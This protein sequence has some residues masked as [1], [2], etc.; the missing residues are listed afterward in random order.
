MIN[1]IVKISAFKLML[2]VIFSVV[3]TIIL[4]SCKQ[5]TE[6]LNKPT[7]PLETKYL[8]Y[9]NWYDTSIPAQI[10]DVSTLSSEELMN[11]KAKMYW[12]NI[13][14]PDVSLKDILSNSNENIQIPVLNLVYNSAER[15]CYNTDTLFSTS[16]SNWGG[17]ILVID[18]DDRTFINDNF[19]IG[20]LSLWLNFEDKLPGG[21]LTID[22]GRISEDVIPNHILDTEDKN[23]NGLLDAGE[24]KGLDGLTDRQEPGYS[25]SNQ[26]PENDDYSYIAGIDFEKINNPEGNQKLNME[27]INYNGNLDLVNSYYSYKIPINYDNNPY[28][29]SAVTTAGWAHM[30]IKLT[31]FASTTGVPSKTNIETLRIWISGINKMVRIKFAEIKFDK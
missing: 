31:G 10:K 25:A 22:L 21:Y 4:S 7:N 3:I 24:D 20:Y 14:P 23:S 13:S 6:P 19:D 1:K 26:D 9:D 15:G 11:Y 30:K 8:N 2:S 18:K 16:D 17:T 12:Y 28:I 27:D 29:D 5:A